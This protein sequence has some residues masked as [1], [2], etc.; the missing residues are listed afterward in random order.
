MAYKRIEFVKK[1]TFGEGES[2]V[3]SHHISYGRNSN[4]T[5]YVAQ[6]ISKS[7][8]SLYQ[9]IRT[10]TSKVNAD[11]A[12]S[13]MLEAIREKYPVGEYKEILSDMSDI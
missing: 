11:K 9:G 3:Y 10:K 6:L 1:E 8:D 2:I 12:L 13:D 7:Y 5:L 4:D